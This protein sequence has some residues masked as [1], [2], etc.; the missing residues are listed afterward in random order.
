M[1]V[2]LGM[3]FAT[4]TAAAEKP[5][6]IWCTLDGKKAEFLTL[7]RARIG[8][9]GE[10]SVLAFSTSAQYGH[11]AILSIDLPDARLIMRRVT[12]G[13]PGFEISYCRDVASSSSNDSY[14]AREVVDPESEVTLKQAGATNGIVEGTF[15]AKVWSLGRPPLLIT[16]GVFRVKLADSATP[17]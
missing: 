1:A 12:V 15:W 9:D 4:A 10:I 8:P 11:P 2:L 14:S 16:N 6:G 17:K 5:F 3:A 13:S 7:A